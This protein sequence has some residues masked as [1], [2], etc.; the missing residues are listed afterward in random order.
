MAKTKNN[1]TYAQL[2]VMAWLMEAPEDRILSQGRSISGD[3]MDCR[4]RFA[5]YYEDEK[6]SLYTHANKTFFPMIEG[7]E[8]VPIV[9]YLNVRHM[10]L[11]LTL[12]L[13]AGYLELLT[14]YDLL[15]KSK[16][17]PLKSRIEPN[18]G[19]YTLSD[20]FYGLT[21]T[22]QQWFR[23]EGGNLYLDAV[24]KRLQLESESRR[25]ILIGCVQQ[26]MPKLNESQAAMRPQG[27]PVPLPSRPTVRP[28]AT[29]VV[30]KETPEGFYVRDVELLESQLKNPQ[31]SYSANPIVDRNPHDFVPR[32]AVLADNVSTA[33]VQR[34]ISVDEQIYDDVTASQSRII[35]ELL[36]ILRRYADLQLQQSFAHK[37]M[38]DEAVSK[39]NGSALAP[40]GCE[41]PLSPG[42]K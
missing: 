35:D 21:E 22:G 10:K 8:Q 31:F 5:K 28:F 25:T 9:E 36:P 20:T 34:V 1:F 7:T 32:D 14:G 38:F 16:T 3:A 27:F 37:D 18:V 12:L 13:R 30:V 15:D 29:A 2:S 4:F 23:S 26:I 41:T 19:K 40:D 42:R 39:A 6:R 17:T 11:N 33:A 24:R